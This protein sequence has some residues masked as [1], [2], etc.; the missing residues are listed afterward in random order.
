[1]TP[2]KLAGYLSEIVAR[3]TDSQ[4]V[5]TREPVSKAQFILIA[6][7]VSMFLADKT[8]EYVDAGLYSTNSHS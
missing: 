7:E 2:Q 8:L 6:A 3:N 4:G 5:W 1:M